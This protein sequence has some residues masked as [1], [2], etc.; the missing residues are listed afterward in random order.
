MSDTPP[1]YTGST[2]P[3]PPATPAPEPAG[4]PQPAFP[5]QGGPRL[6]TRHSLP[7]LIATGAIA[8]VGALLTTIGGQGFPYNAPVEQFFAFG[9]TLDLVAVGIA[10]IVFVVVEIRR[11]D[12][13]RRGNA[14][15]NPYRSVMAILA[16][17]FSGIALLAWTIGGG[18]VELAEL[19]AGQRTRYMEATGALFFAGGLWTLGMIFGAWG[20]RPG[21]NRTSNIL[22]LVA[23]GAG[24]LLIVPTTIAAIVY[25]LGLSD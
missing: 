13:L 20:F 3:P 10:M 23:L 19:A 2:T 17:I 14:V 1:P 24:L 15:V 11:R 5:T 9:L 25:G 16:V 22:A 7:V 21:A 12:E 4:P 18:L 6:L 8:L